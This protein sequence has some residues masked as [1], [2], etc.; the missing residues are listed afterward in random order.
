MRLAVPTFL[1][2]SSNSSKLS[3]RIREGEEKHVV[4][5]LQGDA[6]EMKQEALT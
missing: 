4:L 1:G 3:V 6:M 2:F 5:R